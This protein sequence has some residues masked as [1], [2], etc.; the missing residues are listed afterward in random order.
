VGFYFHLKRLARNVLSQ[1][2]TEGVIDGMLAPEGLTYHDIVALLEQ[3]DGD[4]PPS[5]LKLIFGNLADGIALLAAWLPDGSKDG[6]IEKKEAVSELYSLIS[7][8]LGLQVPTETPP[9]KARKKAARYVLVNEFRS[10]LSMEPPASI[11]MIPVCPSKD[12]QERVKKLAE[13]LRRGHPEAYT[14]LADAVESELALAQTPF[15]P[16]GLGDI[17]TFRFAERILLGYCGELIAR[18]DHE[19]ATRLID[20]RKSCFWIARD[21]SRR[22]QWEACRLMAE[23]GL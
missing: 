20:E 19:A 16:L 1:K 11:S 5:L 2:Y 13:R 9:G 14:V 3:N 6:A 21:I 4:E 7:S 22:A 15:D 18:S 23:L 17:D 12:H 8:R 10:D